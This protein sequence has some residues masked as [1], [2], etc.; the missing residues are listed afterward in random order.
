MSGT[1][2]EGSYTKD[3]LRAAWEAGGQAESDA[4]WTSKWESFDDW[5]ER[6]VRPTEPHG[7]VTR[8]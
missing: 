6:M 5:F 8:K 3:D 2:R 1:V 7:V 4:Y